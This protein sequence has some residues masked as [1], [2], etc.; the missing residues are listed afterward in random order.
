MFSK[1]EIMHPNNNFASCLAGF[2]NPQ[3]LSTGVPSGI[4]YLNIIDRGNISVVSLAIFLIYFAS[5]VSFLIIY[6]HTSKQHFSKSFRIIIDWPS[7]TKEFS[8]W[9]FST[10]SYSELKYIRFWNMPGFSKFDFSLL[11]QNASLKASQNVIRFIIL[12]DAQRLWLFFLSYCLIF[13]LYAL[14]NYRFMSWF[15]NTFKFNWRFMCAI[16]FSHIFVYR[17]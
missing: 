14:E 12:F 16:D 6:W 5:L 3:D 8:I 2:N 17:L 15:A 10:V 13:N 4:K 7:N 11:S 9:H 1:F